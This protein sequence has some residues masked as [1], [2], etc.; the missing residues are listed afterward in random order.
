VAC[1][2]GIVHS[3][4]YVAKLFKQCLLGEE[5]RNRFEAVHFAIKHPKHAATFSSEFAA[6]AAVPA[7]T[8]AAIEAE[9]GRDKALGRGLRIGG[10]GRKA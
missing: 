10:I 9:P 7:A 8:A 1:G 6:T 3:P 4:A 2:C 5:F